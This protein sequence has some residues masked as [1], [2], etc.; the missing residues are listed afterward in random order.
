ML[1]AGVVPRRELWAFRRGDADPVSPRFLGEVK[2][3]VSLHQKVTDM[4]IGVVL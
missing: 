3:F 2:C 1:E 4:Q